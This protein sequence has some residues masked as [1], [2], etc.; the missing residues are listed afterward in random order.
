[1]SEQKYT[2]GP[3][4][5]CDAH[6]AIEN[7]G[8][9]QEMAS[10]RE[11]MIAACCHYVSREEVVANAR[12]IA[13]APD[14]L[15]ALQRLKVELVLSDVPMNYIESHFRPHL[16]KAATAIAKALGK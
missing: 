5:T 2:Q 9:V 1:M 14:L 7:G 6:G 4:V 15:E 10:G 3:W 11:R 8:C 13:A 12:L 16:D